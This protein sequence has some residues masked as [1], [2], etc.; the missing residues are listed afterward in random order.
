MVPVSIIVI[1]VACF[2][3]LRCPFDFIPNSTDVIISNRRAK[4]LGQ[5]I[6]T[7]RFG[8]QVITHVNIAVKRLV[9]LSNEKAINSRHKLLI[10]TVN[11]RINVFLLGCRLP[12][13][14]TRRPRTEILSVAPLDKL[15]VLCIHT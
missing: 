5:N 10:V 7:A 2:H 11:S 12:I 6:F 4:H 8:H 1:I 14:V 9:M 15:T 3:L 13:A